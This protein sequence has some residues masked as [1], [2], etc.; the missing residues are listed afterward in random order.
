MELV[1][2]NYGEYSRDG[3]QFQ[4]T[5]GEYIGQKYGV[6]N[7][8]VTPSGLSAISCVLNAFLRVNPKGVVYYC[9]ELYKETLDLM[10]YL[11]CEKYEC[12]DLDDI[13]SKDS[14]ILIFF[15]SCSN[16]HGRIPNYS[17]LEELRK[18]NTS[19][20]FVVDNTW[21]TSSIFNPFSLGADIV[22]SS[23][24]KY[25]SGGK[26]IGGV[27]ATGKCSLFLTIMDFYNLNGLH[28]SPY[29]CKVILDN[30]KTMD[31]RITKSSQSTYKLLEL[32]KSL[33]KKVYHPFVDN[34]D[35]VDKNFKSVDGVKLI[36]SVLYFESKHNN[37][38]E[39]KKNSIFPLKTSY[40]G[41][42]HRIELDKRDDIVNIRFSIGY[43]DFEIK[44]EDVNKI[45]GY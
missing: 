25:Y 2:N 6:S 14:D 22:V 37:K 18:N 45:I 21:L 43:D 11:E 17:L 9:S 30:I 41:Q 24:T 34:Y 39:V 3:H 36:P 8:Q 35:F 10:E 23:L 19:V 20:I 16:P 4:D 5:L 26:A 7:V 40:G 42:E 15:E 31:E 1:F 38:K 28:I 32:L 33:G 44:Q 13:H 27:I 29:N 12:G